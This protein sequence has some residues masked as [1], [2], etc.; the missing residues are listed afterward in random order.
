MKFFI[1]SPWR[2]KNAVKNLAKT[3]TA[4]GHVAYSFLDNGAGLCNGAPVCD[5]VKTFGRSMV[6]RED[7]PLIKD[8]F[9][10]EKRKVLVLAVGAAIIVVLGFVTQTASAAPLNF[11]TAESITL[12]SPATTLTIATYSVADDGWQFHATLSFLRPCDRYV[13]QWGERDH[14]LQWRR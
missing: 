8:I 13:E 1:T 10:S 9:D 4:R 3:L 12:S 5:E 6:D 11:T 2:N 7:D 14:L